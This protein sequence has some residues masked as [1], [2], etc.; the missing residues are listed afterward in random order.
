VGG[1]SGRS[2]HGNE[3]IAHPVSNAKA[4]AKEL[5]A[6]DSPRPSKGRRSAE[7]GSSDLARL[8]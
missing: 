6:G 5:S 8:G 4:A 1:D 7:R 3:C 2:V